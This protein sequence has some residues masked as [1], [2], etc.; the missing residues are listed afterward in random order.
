MKNTLKTPFNTETGKEYKGPNIVS[1]VHAE[2]ARKY[3]TTE[4]G[5][6]LQ[7][8]AKGFSVT[9]GEHGTH[10]RTFGNGTRK[11]KATGKAIEGSYFRT[12]VLF[13]LAQVQQIAV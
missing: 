8:R 10:C 7:W 2:E 13:N 3:P 12:F 11:S 4:W 5:T 9:K 1:L 6:F